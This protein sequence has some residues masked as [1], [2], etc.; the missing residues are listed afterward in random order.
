MGLLKSAEAISTAKTVA[1][2]RKEEGNHVID[3]GAEI[4]AKAAAKA[5]A[6]KVV[7]AAKA[8][9]K[10]KKGKSLHL[11]SKPWHKMHDV[12]QARVTPQGKYILGTSRRRVGA[13]FGQE[14]FR[15][16]KWDG[17]I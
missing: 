13:G 3:H 6:Q 2:H 7:R 14:R 1:K 4:K 9:A 10:K 12:G 15:T 16:K 8:A 17:K 5:A 11:P